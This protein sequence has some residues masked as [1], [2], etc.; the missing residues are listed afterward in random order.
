MIE[1][2]RKLLT[3]LQTKDLL[4]FFSK[5]TEKER[6]ALAPEVLQWIKSQELVWLNLTPSWLIDSYRFA[7][8]MGREVLPE[9]RRST[10]FV[11]K[12]N[13]RTQAFEN[14]G[15]ENI[16]V[17]QESFKLIE[18][19]GQQEKSKEIFNR[20]AV[21]ETA[22]LALCATA[23]AKEL[24]REGRRMIF[25]PFERAID[26]YVSVF[27]DRRPDWL[28]EFLNDFFAA[29]YSGFWPLWKQLAERNI[30]PPN[31]FDSYYETLFEYVE[32]LPW[33]D[34]PYS[35]ETWFEFWENNPDRMEDFWY[36]FEH[37]MVGHGR[38]DNHCFS[39]L[40]PELYLGLVDR[41]LIERDRFL[42]AI[43]QSLSFDYSDQILRMFLKLMESFHPT[44]EEMAVRQEQYL[45]LFDLQ[46]AVLF[47]FV[48]QM[49][50]KLYSKTLLKLD[51]FFQHIGGIFNDPKKS[52]C[53]K[54]L[55]LVE[56]SVQKNSNLCIS[57]IPV[58][59]KGLVHKTVEVQTASAELVLKYVSQESENF[60]RSILSMKS[61]LF[62]SV[63]LLLEPFLTD[64][65]MS[66]EKTQKEMSHTE[67]NQTESCP[68][69]YE[70]KKETC[71][72]LNRLSLCNRRMRF[73]T[74]PWLYWKTEVMPTIMTFF[75]TGLTVSTGKT[76]NRPVKKRLL[77]E[78]K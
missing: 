17:I 68:S 51:S 59:E 66:Q 19:E 38:R 26:I 58:I 78:R 73:L 70:K 27:Q 9:L 16:P 34:T 2:L 10:S 45:T 77:C 33:Y 42:D 61:Q 4:V 43:L 5:R 20:K 46:K 1:E 67:S 60:R 71:H 7:S 55:K 29:E 6:R 63:V 64:R 31:R 44:L 24:L 21:L 54:M 74:L 18:A 37:S 12:I 14:A 23:S 35:A 25:P 8:L 11:G 62:P 49:V 56:K 52:H 76:K 28:P 13:S 72:H 30:I 40:R 65:N 57:A 39:S 3:A 75:S 50:T 22:L 15:I 53:L 32:C 47:P 41:G 48:C 36:P 69:E